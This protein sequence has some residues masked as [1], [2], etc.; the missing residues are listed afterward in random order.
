MREE[1]AIQQSIVDWIAVVAPAVICYACPN[2]ARRTA[3]GRASNAVPGLRRGVFDL[4]LV[5]PPGFVNMTVSYGPTPA[6]I[7]CKTK[8]GVLSNDQKAFRAALIQADVPFCEARS[9]DDVRAFFKEIG[10]P[11]REA[12]L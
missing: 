10:V 8:T 12:K 1:D 3:S 5:L 6:F 4:A 11:T 7:E 2:A 9:I